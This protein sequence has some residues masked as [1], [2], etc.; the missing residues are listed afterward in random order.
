M[1]FT[2]QVPLG[3]SPASFQTGCMTL[4]IGTGLPL[5]IYIHIYILSFTSLSLF[6]LLLLF[7]PFLLLLFLSVLSFLW[8]WGLKPV[9]QLE[10][11]S[12]I[13]GS[14]LAVKL[15]SSLWSSHLTLPGFWD[16]K[17]VHHACLLSTAWKI[18]LFDISWIHS[19]NKYAYAS[20]MGQVSI[21]DMWYT[22]DVIKPAKIILNHLKFTE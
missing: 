8:Y 20:T 15:F 11:H 18:P 14:H 2:S 22:K 13:V 7:L 10:V 5:E 1:V 17:R 9:L 16:Y 12:P 6:L 19:W 3:A 4:G 21:H